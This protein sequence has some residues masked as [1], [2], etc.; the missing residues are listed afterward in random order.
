M[1][2]QI[3]QAFNAGDH[4]LIEAGTGTGKSLAYL[5]PAALWAI[6]NGQRVV[7]AT[8]TLN[9]QD[10][11]L[12]K[13][14]PQ[15]QSLLTL[16]GFSAPRAALLKGRQN[17]LC[18]RRLHA[19]RLNQRLSPAEM[20]LLAKVL[21]WLPT[22]TTGD[23]AELALSNPAEKAAWLR[24]CSDAAACSYERCSA[25]AGMPGADANALPWH[26]YYLAARARAERAHLVIVNHALLLADLATEGRVLPPYRHLIVDETHRLEEAATD[27]LT[28]RVEWPAVEALL[29]RLT[30][31][32]DLVGTAPP[33][34]QCAADECGRAALA[35]PG[36]AG[37]ARRHPAG[38]PVGAIGHLRPAA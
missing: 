9:L 31:S 30:S 8:N 20:T 5:L 27:Q 29:R 4:L 28:Y 3:A 19:W 2:G 6:Q 17:Y 34:R 37:A 1:A 36:R 15:V 13:E 22:T 24:I 7:I 23:L 14:V 33:G 12:E 35:G 21:V 16:A 32:G 18:V 26:D 11:L 25:H 10:Q 38:F